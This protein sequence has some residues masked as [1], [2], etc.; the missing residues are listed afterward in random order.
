MVKHLPDQFLLE[1]DTFFKILSYYLP[2]EQLR[3]N[4]HFVDWLRNTPNLPDQ[5]ATELLYNLP[6]PREAHYQD[7]FNAMRRKITTH[8]QEVEEFLGNDPV[9]IASEMLNSIQLLEIAIHIVT[10]IFNMVKLL[11]IVVSVLIIYSLLMV[12][13]ESKTFEIA[14]QRMVGLEKSGIITLIVC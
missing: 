10:L 6:K 1:Y 9:L 3:G 7:D 11:F 8:L 4:A 12:S 5:F 14:V 13:I 2:D